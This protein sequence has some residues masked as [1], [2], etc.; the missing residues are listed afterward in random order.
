V[1][2]RGARLNS[3]STDD[4]QAGLDGGIVVLELSR[5][6]LE[7]QEAL[8]HH[9][10]LK[11][12]QNSMHIAQ[13]P[14]HLE[15]GASVLLKVSR[16]VRPQKY[17]QAVA[18]MAQAERLQKRHIVVSEELEL[19]V[20]EALRSLPGRLKVRVKSCTRHSNRCLVRYMEKNTFLCDSAA[21]ALSATSG[22]THSTCDAHPE[23]M[24]NPRRAPI[25]V[26]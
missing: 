19:A 18:R 11:S 2:P 7:V 6:P 10:Q 5:N 24:A 3:Q 13:L 23:R 15:G 17:Y 22:C 20:D 4:S 9:M 26:S 8:R 21:L 12:V 25:P 16:R 1:S 14:V